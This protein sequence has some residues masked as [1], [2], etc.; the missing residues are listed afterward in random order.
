MPYYWRRWPRRRRRR[1]WRRRART[2]FRRR[3]FWRRRWPV[4]PFTRKLKKITLKEWQPTKI[5]KLK[6]VGQYPLFEGTNERVGNNNTQY[7]DSVAPYLYP[8]GGLFSITVFTLQGLYELHLKSR[9]WWTKSNCDLPLIK[10]TGCKIKLFRATDVD[11]VTVY[12]RC[13][14]L[15]ATEQ[16]YQSCQPSVLLLNKHKKVVQCKKYNKFRKP[17][18]I[19]RVP[20]PSLMLNK[21]YFQNEFTNVPLLMLL[22][23]AVSLDRYYINSKAI[24]STMGFISLNTQVFQYHNFKLT[25]TTP[26][27]PNDDFWLYTIGGRTTTFRTATFSQLILLGNTK[28]FQPGETPNG[29]AGNWKN[30]IERYFATPSNWGNPFF[31]EYLNQDSSPIL[32]TQHTPQQIIEITKDN[33]DKKLS[34]NGFT[35]I[36][37]PLLTHC[38]Y[39]PQA[40][41]SHNAVFISR[42]TTDN[43]KWHDPDDSKL[44]TRGLPIWLLFFGYKD[45]LEK[46]NYVQRLD[47]DYVFV[48]VSD[49]ITPTMDYYVPL[50][51]NFLQGK[52][53]YE[54]D[55]HRKPYDATNWHPKVNFQTSTISKIINTG[56]ATAKLPEKSS[57][58]AHC[59]YCFYFK[60]GG[61]PPAMDNVCD[62]KKQPKFPTPGNLLSS[63]LLQ[64]PETPMQYY[65][66][67]FDQRREMLTERA[68]KRIKKDHGLT[69]TIFK[70][71][72]TTHLDVLPQTYE[73]TS[74]EDSSEEE[75]DQETLQFQLH[76]QR[77]KQRKLRDRILELLKMTQSL[78]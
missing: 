12:A 24:S 34:E 67:A 76:K 51:D 77:R 32:I 62:P 38:R 10:Y 27:K 54:T 22:S 63:T 6:I 74:T 3:R 40:D 48:I 56:P 65:L 29:S 36:T 44:S 41:M 2:A 71:T 17:Y 37:K 66:S 31:P 58:E 78:E 18:K 7:I 50:D 75:K 16:L 23:S 1:F 53:P 59:Q 33:K 46:A 28:D 11:Y 57:V 25:T 4:R 21:W 55:E 15:T 35:E 5:N 14:S 13:G 61:C 47:T 73:E 72:G 9:N 70:P 49:H 8:G 42:I 20:P 45:W 30:E 52:S 69:K 39:N 68:A 19:I 43:T 26:Y 60:L 64:N